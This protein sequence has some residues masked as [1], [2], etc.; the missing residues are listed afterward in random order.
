LRE[1]NGLRDFEKRILRLSGA[2]MEVKGSWRKLHN[3]ELNNVYFQPNIVRVIKASFAGHMTYIGDLRFVYRVLDGKP[4]S[5]RPLE[6]P[7]CRWEDNIKLDLREIGIDLT[8][9]I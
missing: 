8:I 3:D 2:K 7:R 6:R 9:W 1:E 5:R 4:E